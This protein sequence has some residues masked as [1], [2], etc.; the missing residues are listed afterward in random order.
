MASRRCSVSRTGRA[1]DDLVS[2]TEHAEPAHPLR[3]LLD[4]RFYMDGLVNSEGGLW[5]MLLNSLLLPLIMAAFFY[6][7]P[8]LLWTGA[9]LLVAFIGYEAYVMWHRRHPRITH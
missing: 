1:L 5:L 8:V 7:V 3:A 6:P 2:S 9:A 4:H